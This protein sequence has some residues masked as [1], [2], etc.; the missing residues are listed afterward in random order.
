VRLRERIGLCWYWDRRGLYQANKVSSR[1]KA[2]LERLGHVTSVFTFSF[3]AK[4]EFVD[5][6]IGVSA[7]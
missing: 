4:T 7:D 1:S 3:E 2:F 6:A 5:G